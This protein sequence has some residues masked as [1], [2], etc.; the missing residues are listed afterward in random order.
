MP[1]VTKRQAHLRS[2]IF[3][4]WS[5]EKVLSESEGSGEDDS[6]M[7]VDFTVDTDDERFFQEKFDL[8]D[9]GDLLEL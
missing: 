9:I 4:R 3:E 8:D 2:A 5:N 7:D 1:A 6:E